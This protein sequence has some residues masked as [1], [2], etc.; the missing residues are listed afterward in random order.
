MWVIADLDVRVKDSS[1]W[2]V[3]YECVA[4]VIALDEF[5]A[6]VWMCIV[7]RPLADWN[8]SN[9]CKTEPSAI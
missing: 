4:M 9:P 2:A 8:E 6:A 5:S 1:I 7:S 3:F